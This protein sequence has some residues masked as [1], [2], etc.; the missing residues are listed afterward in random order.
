MVSADSAWTDSPHTIFAANAHGEARP[1]AHAL[2]RQTRRDIVHSS[3][4][5]CA[6]VSKEQGIVFRVRIRCADNGVEEQYLRKQIQ[7]KLMV[8]RIYEELLNVAGGRAAVCRVL[9]GGHHPKCLTEVFL[10]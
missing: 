2:I 8:A 3:H 7:V 1:A 9:L 4:H 5:G 10:M 6:V